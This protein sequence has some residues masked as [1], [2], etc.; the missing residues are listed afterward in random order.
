MTD[1]YFTR[2][3]GD[4]TRA[5]NG[6]D[7]PRR[8]LKRAT[9]GVVGLLAVLIGGLAIGLD[10]FSLCEHRCR[11]ENLGRYFATSG[12]LVWLTILSL[13]PPR[14]KDMDPGWIWTAAVF[15]GCVVVSVAILLAIQTC[16]KIP[17][18]GCF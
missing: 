13:G 16:S 7:E 3:L 1:D 10:G 12:V 5:A 4:D 18:G 6:P 17:G 11:V 15:V 2:V 8:A 14:R 9:F